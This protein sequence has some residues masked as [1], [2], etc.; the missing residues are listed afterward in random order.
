MLLVPSISAGWIASPAA[1]SASTIPVGAIAVSA[2]SSVSP[3]GMAAPI[4]AA[5]NGAVPGTYVTLAPSRLLDT[6]SG[7]GVAKGPVGSAGRVNVRVLGR[8]GV[9]ASGVGSVVLSL[10]ATQPAGS[11]AVRVWPDGKPMPGTSNLNYRRG[12]TV[13]N[14]AVVPVGADGDIAV[15]NQGSSVQLIADVTGYYR[16]GTAAVPGAFV[17]LPATR[18][19]DTRSGVGAPKHPAAADTVLSVKVTGRGGVPTGATTAVVTVAAVN[20]RAAGY[21]T[22]WASRSARPNTSTINFVA[23]QTVANLAYVPIGP[24]GSIQLANSS[25]GSVDLLAD[26]AG[27]MVPGVPDQPGT[28][29]SVRPVRLLDTRD[30][31][32]LYGKPVA[33]GGVITPQMGGSGVPRD[34]VLAVVL[35]LTVTAPRKGGF[36]TAWAAGSGRPS[37]STVNFGAGQTVANFA[38]VS[39]GAADSVNLF[40][41]SSGPTDLIADATGYYLSAHISNI[42]LRW[43]APSAPVRQ[44]Y[45]FM[46]SSCVSAVFCEALTF[47]G[48][49]FH[50]DG[51]RLTHQSDLAGSLFQAISCAS[52][53]FCAAIDRMGEIFTYTSAAGWSAPVKVLKRIGLSDVSCVSSTFCMAV[54]HEDGAAVIYDGTRWAQSPW[55]TGA[56]ALRVSCASATSCFVADGGSSVFHYR[57]A[58]LGW[59]ED[60]V[61]AAGSM[62]V[63]VSCSRTDLCGATDW[64]GNVLTFNGA[65]WSAPITLDPK[66]AADLVQ[67]VSLSC[68]AKFCFAYDFNGRYFT[69]DGR[70]WSGPSAI[71]L[72]G[73]I[74]CVDATFCLSATGAGNFATF[75]GST[76]SAPTMVVPSNSRSAVSCISATSCTA[77]TGG[78]QVQ[79]FDGAAWSTP[80]D[81]DPYGG[82][83]SVSCT[84][85]SFC[86][87]VDSIGNVLTD[88]GTG[89][90]TPR[91]INNLAAGDKTISCASAAFCA[92]SDQAGQVAVM[93]G[94]VWGALTPVLTGHELVSI[95][96]PSATFCAAVAADG[97]ASTFNGQTWTKAAR[98]LVGSLVAVSCPVAGWCMATSH[99]DTTFVD[100]SAAIFTGGSWHALNPDFSELDAI[101]CASVMFCVAAETPNAPRTFNGAAWS[102]PNSSTTLPPVFYSISCPTIAFCG[103]LVE[104]GD[105]TNFLTGR[106]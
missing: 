50:Y 64:Q 70:V 91:R 15:L 63:D 58:T 39:I 89:W 100:H 81:I 104:D 35:N 23:G 7:V 12:Q 19:L 5:A 38:T 13:A 82:L 27:Y 17:A 43:S 83:R 33:A 32:A 77:V 78:G 103:A 101:S 14:A 68:Q 59:S 25:R 41:G 51:Q 36:I 24:D 85:D 40:N 74:S 99:G 4:Q 52:V 84:A 72:A 73:A 79:R 22:A 76:W 65:T 94:T 95:S 90:T 62:I 67:N 28:Y 96:C 21:V 10:T 66:P 34:G 75:N 60:Q 86:A 80:T 57:G 18:L 3:A 54:S 2:A 29:V 69:F 97:Y 20:P 61:D 105:T 71:D 31:Y 47:D 56:G 44:V 46:S 49:V 16:I 106:G 88:N 6:R 42:K 8:G 93:R 30:M 1:A 98:A 37:T 11:G 55:L 53:D 92:I 87:A 48:R 9:P 45:G 102:E 26:V